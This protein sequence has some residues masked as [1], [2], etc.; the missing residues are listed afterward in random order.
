VARLSGRV[1]YLLVLQH[2]TARGMTA[3]GQVNSEDD[4]GEVGIDAIE[5]LLDSAAV[6]AE[7]TGVLRRTLESLRVFKYATLEA[8]V[9]VTRD[10]GH[11]NLSLEGKKRLGIFPP[12]VKSINFGNVPITLLARTFSRK[13]TP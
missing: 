8:D 13:E 9:R 12:P 11:V 5:K 3:V 6:Q 1:R 10:G 7:S 4:G 2:S